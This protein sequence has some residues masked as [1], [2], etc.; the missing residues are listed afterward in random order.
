MRQIGQWVNSRVIIG[1]TDRKTNISNNFKEDWVWEVSFAWKLYFFVACKPSEFRI[2]ELIT[3]KFPNQ[4]LRQIKVFVNY[5][6]TY[7]QTDT[8]K[9]RRSDKC[10][11]N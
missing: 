8:L 4:N 11:F 9:N 1:Q 3:K 2:L 6:L 5:D 10:P 7:K